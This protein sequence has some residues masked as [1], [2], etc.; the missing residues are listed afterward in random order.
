[1][2]G[3][4]R[5]VT[6]RRDAREQLEA[7]NAAAQRAREVAEAANLAKSEF[8][9]RMS[10][11]LRTPLNSI[12]GFAQLLALSDLEES[13]ADNVRQILHSGRHLLALIDEVLDLA[14]IEV[15]GVS[16]SVESVRAGD[17]VAEAV[18]LMGPLAD[19]R[20]I[21]LTAKW[22]DDGDGHLLADRRR[23]HQILVNYIGNAIK[24]SPPGSSVRVDVAPVAD[25]CL[26]ITIT[27]DGPGIPPEQLGLLF[28]PFERLGA[29]RSG[30]EGTG[31]GLAHSKSLAEH[32][33]G[34]VGVD[35]E[36]GRG[37]SFWVELPSSPPPTNVLD[38]REGPPAVEAAVTGLTGTVLYIEDNRA[39][40]LLLERLLRRRPGVHLR[41]AMLGREGLA[42]ARD[43]QPDVIALDLHLPDIPGDTVLSLLRSDPLTERIP[44]V[45]LSADATRRQVEELLAMGAVAYLTKPLDVRRLLATLDELLEPSEAP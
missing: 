44:V 14:R 7:A 18:S 30:V 1:V 2:Y 38:D 35:S 23:L 12:L 9:S 20:G 42:M 6:E 36:P 45:I 3:T 33:G 29:E 11:E 26:R 15:G 22:E 10:H 24:Y 40:I 21:E 5:D 8:L 13:E 34:R 16:L 4:A 37:S 41:T 39:N 27:D 32:M 43:V 31:L 28:A 25:A 19:S 17:A